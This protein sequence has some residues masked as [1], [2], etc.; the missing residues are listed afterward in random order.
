MIPKILHYVWFGDKEFGDLENMCLESWRK[1]LPDYKIMRWDNSCI[2]KMDNLYFKQ[3]IENKKYAFASDYAR[4]KALWEYG[5]IYVDTDEEVLKSLDEF[6][7]HD[8]FMGCQSCGS[9]KGPNPALIGA[10]PH[11]EVIK[12]LLSVYDDIKFVNDDGSFNMTTNPAYFE[13]IL[14]EVYHIKT[15]YIEEGKIEFHPNSFMYDCYL[16]GKRNNTSFA[17]HHYAGSWKPDWNMTDK[18]K[19]SLFGKNY[20]LRKYKRN[21]PDAEL[22]ANNGEKIVLKI[23]TSKRSFLVISQ[24]IG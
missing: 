6:L 14:N 1:Y 15:T 17:T 4:L 3:A 9:A 7:V 8:Y 16:F 21:N 12:N 13:K 2:D 23:K 20:I 5:G 24:K 22:V 10:T 19:F 18:A 11:N